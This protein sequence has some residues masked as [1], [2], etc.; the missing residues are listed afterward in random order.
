MTRG[1]RPTSHTP[2][3]PVPGCRKSEPPHAPVVRFLGATAE[4]REGDFLN[5]RSGIEAPRAWLD[6]TTRHGGRESVSFGIKYGSWRDRRRID[7]EYVSRHTEATRQSPTRLLAP[8]AGSHPPLM[9]A[10]GP[11]SVP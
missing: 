8:P 7:G 10:Q 2:W 3:V 9:W 5:Q 11:L 6:E 4:D 1:P